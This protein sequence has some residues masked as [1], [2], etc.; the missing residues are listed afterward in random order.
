MHALEDVQ[1]LSP[2]TPFVFVTG[3]LDEE[4]AVQC[5][6]A[7]AWDYVLKDRLIRLVPAVTASLGLRATRDALQKSEGQLLQ[8][9]KMDALG[10]LAGGVA[11]DYNNLTTA[12]LGYA[13]LVM[14]TLP[15]GDA[16]RADLA[17][18]QHAAERAADLSHQL[19]AF[20]RKQVI[21]SR[22][23]AWNDVVTGTER[24]LGR[25]VGEHIT[26]RSVLAADLP[27]VWSDPGQLQQI[28]V[29]LVVNAR[30]AM[31][32]GGVLTV[33]T[34]AVVIAGDHLLEHVDAQPGPHVCLRV[35]DTGVGMDA[36]TQRRVFEPFFTTK[37]RG[38]GTGLGLATVYGIVRQS[39]GHVTLDSTVGVGTTVSVYLPAASGDVVVEIA[40]APARPRD[41]AGT[42]TILIAEDDAA[43]RGLARR[44]LQTCGYTTIEAA[45][46]SEAVR[47]AER[48]PQLDLLLTDMVMPELGG[49]ELFAAVRR[50][51]PH[52]KVVY[53]SGYTEQAIAMHD[54]AQVGGAFLAKPFTPAA[55]VRAVR[56]ELDR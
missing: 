37:V 38:K 30:D 34:D 4:T 45:T 41:L 39:G 9:H 29:N 21:R 12:M 35:R 7:G 13:A 3:S 27:P 8:M 22:R 42:E 18:I 17:E 51:H 43:V 28:L 49:L 44:L 19:L 46:G 54:R 48:T 23:V 11:H 16:R 52:V 2:E 20:S 50:V 26:F 33:E 36:A 5:L 14:E 25:L 40:G 47:A 55:L 24:M 56:E 6:K 10:R 31:P 32:G 15:E 53:M 1:R